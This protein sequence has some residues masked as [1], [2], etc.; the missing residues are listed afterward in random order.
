MRQHGVQ[1]QNALERQAN[2]KR[3]SVQHDERMVG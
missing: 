3:R 2:G 1:S